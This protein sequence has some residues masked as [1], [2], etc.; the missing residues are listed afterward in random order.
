MFGFV[1]VDVMVKSLCVVCAVSG[2]TLEALSNLDHLVM[3]SVAFLK[4]RK[5]NA[6]TLGLAAL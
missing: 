3:D 5:K 2:S 4:E 6:E 1:I